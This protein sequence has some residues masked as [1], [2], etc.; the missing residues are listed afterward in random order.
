MKKLCLLSFVFILFAIQPAFSQFNFGV[1]AVAK[2][3]NLSSLNGGIMAGIGA[4]FN[5]PLSGMGAGVDV[6]FDNRKLDNKYDNVFDNHY[7][8]ITIPINFKYKIGLPRLIKLVFSIGPYVSIPLTKDLKDDIRTNDA[9]NIFGANA[10]FGVGFLKHYQID[11][12][13]RFDVIQNDAMDKWFNKQ[14]GYYISF[15]YIF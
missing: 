10:S 7:N 15:F 12:G 2:S 11:A 3:K 4:E 6:L 9:C 1:K 8:F 14:N 5:I 13:Y